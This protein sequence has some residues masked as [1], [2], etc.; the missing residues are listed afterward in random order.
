MPLVEPP[1]QYLFDSWSSLPVDFLPDGELTRVHQAATA[2]VTRLGE[3]DGFKLATAT[4][5]TEQAKNISTT[6]SGEVD[7]FLVQSAPM[8]PL[9]AY[10]RG[11]VQAQLSQ[12]EA[13]VA[14]A[15]KVLDDGVQS[16]EAKKKE[17][18]DAL[19]AI[20][21]TAASA[22]AAIFTQD[23]LTEAANVEQSAWNWL[24][25]AGT[26]GAAAMLLAASFLYFQPPSTSPVTYLVQYSVTKLVLVGGLLAAAF[27]CGG[28]YRSLRHQAAIN[29]HRGNSL[30][31]F[32]AFLAAAG[33]RQDV[34]DAILLETT[35]SI[36]AVAPTGFLNA[37]ETNVDSGPKIT[38]VLK[39]LG[40]SS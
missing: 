8:L 26:F 25:A 5:P 9:L 3:I 22:G 6:L 32:Q 4:N 2:V 33:D 10:R 31:T 18:D 7:T 34:R 24:K 15:G 17:I 27:W 30:K 29:K 13:S 11:D 28:I 23:F 37:T 36:F 39:G 19:V 35:R 38:D 40:K 12:I 21:N 1:A 20:R 16:I 14:R